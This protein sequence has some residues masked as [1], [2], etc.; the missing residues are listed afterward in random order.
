[1]AI[2]AL[3]V[4][5]EKAV[6]ATLDEA[7]AALGSAGLVWI[8]ADERTPEL[9]AVLEAL[10]LH[11][12]TIEDLF[13]VRA[14]PKVED[15]GRYLYVLAHAV[16]LKGGLQ[17]AELDIVLGPNWVVT[18]HD[19]D[20]IVP[21]QVREELLRQGRPPDRARILHRLLDRIAD[22]ALPCMDAFDD[23]IEKLEEAAVQRIPRRTIVPRILAL[24]SD[25]HRLRRSAL[26]HRE[27]L[28]RIARG[29]FA[30]V[31]EAA[32]PFF[33]DVHDHFV[34]LAD[35]ADDAR[36]LLTGVLE[37]H[38]S[39]V[40]NRL[41]EIMKVL[42]MIATV[43]LPLSFIAGVYGMNFEHM[44]ELHWRY[45]YAYAWAVMLATGLGLIYWFRRRGWF[46]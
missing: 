39:M 20:L 24:R 36:D 45:G 6:P 12:L 38:L 15:F 18:H 25:L 4:Q 11:P 5:G 2:T 16:R 35:Q 3:I 14:T 43:F 19:P 31:P 23:A 1:M 34:R 17:E 27:V 46:G 42:T 22:D 41:N 44:P 21:A 8:D 29:E 26:H 7:R 32:L 37:A 10:Q 28:L 30:L 9:D 40:S 13:E 33:R